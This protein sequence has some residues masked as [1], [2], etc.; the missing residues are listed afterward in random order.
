MLSRKV[1]EAKHLR[2][3]VAP[4]LRRTGIEAPQNDRVHFVRDSKSAWQNRAA[5]GILTDLPLD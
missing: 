1:V 4:L 5:D 2:F 3:F